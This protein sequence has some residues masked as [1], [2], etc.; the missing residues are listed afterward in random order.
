MVS[1][2]KIYRPLSQRTRTAICCAHSVTGEAWSERAVSFN[3]SRPFIPA[4]RPEVTRAAAVPRRATLV[5]SSERTHGRLATDAHGPK[6]NLCIVSKRK[7]TP[8]DSP[9]SSS[10]PG[11]TR[12]T[13]NVSAIR[14]SRRYRRQGNGS[15]DR[16]AS[17]PWCFIH[18]PMYWQGPGPCCCPRSFVPW[19]KPWFI[20]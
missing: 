12:D 19:T 10:P 5:M 18:A 8:K 13:R 16:T 1:S 7:R 15:S 6:K 2:P 11:K 4:H 14:P 20:T 17:V 9:G 3:S